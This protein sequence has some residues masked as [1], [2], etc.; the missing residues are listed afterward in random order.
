MVTTM[1]SDSL[2]VDSRGTKK[3]AGR[4]RRLSRDECVWGG[5]GDPIALPADACPLP[6]AQRPAQ[7]LPRPLGASLL[8][9]LP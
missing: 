1:N 3:G 8:R 7:G 2:D 4:G 6:T 9:S 5:R